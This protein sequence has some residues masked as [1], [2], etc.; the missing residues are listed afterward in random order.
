[1]AKQ[2]AIVFLIVVAVVVFDVFLFFGLW[3]FSKYIELYNF[4]YQHTTE[5][6]PGLNTTFKRRVGKSV[7]LVNIN[8]IT[9]FQKI[10]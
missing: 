1:M 10:K 6:K 4:S 2:E 3:L 8:F 5:S 9:T 7:Y